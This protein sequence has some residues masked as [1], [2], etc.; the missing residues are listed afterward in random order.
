MEKKERKILIIGIIIATILLIVSIIFGIIYYQNIINNKK[1]IEEIKRRSV[2]EST[3]S[4]DKEAQENRDESVVITN[5]NIKDTTIKSLSDIDYT[6]R[7]FIS[8]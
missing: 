2:N 5:G 8:I 7:W 1:N 6:K 3:I 4:S